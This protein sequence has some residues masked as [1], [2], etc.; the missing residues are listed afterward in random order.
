MMIYKKKKNLKYKKLY[1]IK[2]IILTNFF[3]FF[4]NII[5]S[6]PA[7]IFFKK[8]HI[9]RGIVPLASFNL[10]STK[11]IGFYHNNMKPQTKNTIHLL[12]QLPHEPSIPL[13]ETS[14][15]LSPFHQPSGITFL[16]PGQK[17][18]GEVVKRTPE[19]VCIYV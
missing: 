10:A 13:E 12:D 11:K 3:F 17:S 15:F 1:K 16:A 5:S 6:Y 7:Y 8:I 18:Q 9:P 2:I 4:F 14:F 19:C